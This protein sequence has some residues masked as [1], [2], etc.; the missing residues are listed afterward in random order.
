[1]GKKIRFHEESEPDHHGDRKNA[2]VSYNQLSSETHD[3]AGQ[4][5]KSRRGAVQKPNYAVLV[6]RCRP[7]SKALAV[8]AFHGLKLIS[9][10]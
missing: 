9:V 8:I 2:N 6:D 10:S 7:K 3:R 4:K 5:T 1:M